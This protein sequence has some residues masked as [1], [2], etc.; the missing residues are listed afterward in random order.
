MNSRNVTHHWKFNLSA[1]DSVS[2]PPPYKKFNSTFYQPISM[3]LPP[4]PPSSNH[5]ANTELRK[6]LSH[7]PLS[8]QCHYML[9][10]SFITKENTQRDHWQRHQRFQSRYPPFSRDGSQSRKAVLIKSPMWQGNV[11]LLDL[12][13][14][15]DPIPSR[16]T[17]LLWE[18][19]LRSSAK[20]SCNLA[21]FDDAFEQNVLPY[22]KLL[23]F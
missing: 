12:R 6:H 8:G 22:W 23:D 5:K 14:S 11:P 16:R 2:N 10:S 9:I 3:F 19:G 4:P 17:C 15:N 13:L 18:N 7:I 1:Q 20:I 21:T